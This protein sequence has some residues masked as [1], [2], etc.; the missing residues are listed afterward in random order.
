MSNLNH[1]TACGLVKPRVTRGMYLW[2]VE[3]G[4]I[5]TVVPF[6]R[7]VALQ[8]CARVNGCNDAVWPLSFPLMCELFTAI[9]QETTD[10]L[11]PGVTSI[12]LVQTTGNYGRNSW[13]DRPLGRSFIW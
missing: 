4:G 8:I 6:Q 12:L 7:R 1:R 2:T 13:K 9:T 5:R 10:S 11:T 3:L